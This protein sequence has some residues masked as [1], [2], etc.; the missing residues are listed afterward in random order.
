MEISEV[1]R[2]AV[3]SKRRW[4]PRCF[5]GLTDPVPERVHFPG[6]GELTHFN[7][8]RPKAGQDIR[9]AVA[10]SLNALPDG[11]RNVVLWGSETNP[12]NNEEIA[13]YIDI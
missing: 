2:M 12:T 10:E 13:V 3:P 11:V 6:I 7:V 4:V 8:S 5:T 1:G 9:K